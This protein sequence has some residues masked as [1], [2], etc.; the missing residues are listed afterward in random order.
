MDFN[1]SLINKTG[2]LGDD[3]YFEDLVILG[4]KVF[5]SFSG[6]MWNF[7]NMTLAL[8]EY[9]NQSPDDKRIKQSGIYI[10]PVWL[11]AIIAGVSF[12]LVV[13]AAY[14]IFKDKGLN[15][16]LKQHPEYEKI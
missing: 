13:F 1:I 15:E 6:V 10:M 4:N 14:V 2:P 12:T 11:F 9:P 7:E 3:T 5:N 8:Q 16:K